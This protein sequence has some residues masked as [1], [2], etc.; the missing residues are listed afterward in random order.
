[1]SKPAWKN[2]EPLSAE[3]QVALRDLIQ[4]IGDAAKAAKLLEISATSVMRGALGLGMRRG[5]ILLIETR[6]VELSKKAA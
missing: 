1:M 4:Q 5:T 2:G 3:T 6:L